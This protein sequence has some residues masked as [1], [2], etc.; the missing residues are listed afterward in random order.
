MITG[1]V[2][3]VTP[4]LRGAV[5]VDVS[6]IKAYKTGRLKIAKS[7]PIMS[8]TL[9]STCKRC[10]GLTKG[11]IQHS[12]FFLAWLYTHVSH[13]SMAGIQKCDTKILFFLIYLLNCV[14]NTLV[15]SAPTHSVCRR[16]D[17]LF[18]QKNSEIINIILIITVG[19]YHYYLHT[20]FG[21]YGSA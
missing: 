8:V 11:T 1:K 7:G 6:L 17:S 18:C 3:S 14:L 15:E 12:C 5:T 21:H 19:Q 4:G 16:C 9:T 13:A 20:V 10:P 2:T